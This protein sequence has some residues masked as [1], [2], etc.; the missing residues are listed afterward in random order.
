MLGKMRKGDFASLNRVAILGLNE[1]GTFEQKLARDEG[2]SQV[3]IW[4]KSAPADGIA[5]SNPD[6]RVC[7]LKE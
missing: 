6:A 1:K 7:L 4:R 3:S 2:A 5:G